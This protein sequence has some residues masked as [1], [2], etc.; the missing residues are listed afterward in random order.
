MTEKAISRRVSLSD[1]DSFLA[2]SDHNPTVKY[3]IEIQMSDPLHSDTKIE[4]EELVYQH[5]R[6]AQGDIDMDTLRVELKEDMSRRTYVYREGD[7][8]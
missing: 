3:T 7:V 5:I 6:D 4:L 1:T 8:F 2:R